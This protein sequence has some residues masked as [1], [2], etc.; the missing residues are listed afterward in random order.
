MAG[1]S[2]YFLLPNLSGKLCATRAI[3]LSVAAFRSVESPC[4]YSTGKELILFFWHLSSNGVDN[5]KSMRH[6]TL[7]PHSPS[8]LLISLS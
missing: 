7:V 5:R 2:M 6:K 1:S 3:L 8:S 4:L